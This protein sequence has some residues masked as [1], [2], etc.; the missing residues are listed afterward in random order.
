MDTLFE[1]V[2]GAVT[3]IADSLQKNPH[4][5]KDGAILLLEN[6]LQRLYHINTILSASKFNSYIIAVAD[7]LRIMIQELKG[8]EEDRELLVRRRG[9]PSLPLLPE[10]LTKYIG[11]SFHSGRHSQVKANSHC[12][13][14][15]TRYDQKCL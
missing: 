9:R 11:A 5:D 14:R 13:R 4:G 1:A 7:S 15:A 8:M 2:E 10:E 3:G 6:I 12:T